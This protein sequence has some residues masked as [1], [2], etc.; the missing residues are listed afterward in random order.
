M[1]AVV[2]AGV[3][4]LEISMFRGV[5]VTKTA[6]SNILLVTLLMRRPFHVVVTAPSGLLHVNARRR[7]K[8]VKS[9]CA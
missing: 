5:S 8:P 2:A 3:S 9:M 7:A 4:F 1:N 6:T